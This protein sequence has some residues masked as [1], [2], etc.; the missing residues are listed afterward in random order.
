MP[1]SEKQTPRYYWDADVFLSVINATPDRM[2][3][4]N[5]VLD[6]LGNGKIEIYTSMLSI[7]E[8]AAARSEKDAKAL[9]PKIN[10]KIDSLWR[11]PSPIKLVDIYPL[12]AY[13]A[14]ELMRHAIP[15]GWALQAADAIHL[16]TAQR[17]NVDEYHTYEDKLVK[18]SQITGYRILEPR[19]DRLAFPHTDDEKEL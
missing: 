6:D 19:T 2:P 18:F 11:P 4:L 5:A 1:V 15:Y 9:D 17:M 14:R 13:Q 3:V 7:V 10:E 16:A 8:V 12:L